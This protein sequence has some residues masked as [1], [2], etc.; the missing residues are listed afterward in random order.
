MAQDFGRDLL[1]HNGPRLNGPGGLGGKISVHFSSMHDPLL[2][3]S[4][5]A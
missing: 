3:F 4:N 1:G 5:A 2:H